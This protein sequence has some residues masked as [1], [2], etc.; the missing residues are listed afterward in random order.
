MIFELGG[1]LLENVFLIFPFPIASVDRTFLLAAF[2]QSQKQQAEFFVKFSSLHQSFV[3]PPPS[4]FLQAWICFMAFQ[5][6]PSCSN[7]YFSVSPN[8]FFLY[9]FF[10]LVP[11]LLLAWLFFFSLPHFLCAL[12]WFLR[13]FRAPSPPF[14][15]SYNH[16]NLSRLLAHYCISVHFFVI[17]LFILNIVTFINLVSMTFA[18]PTWS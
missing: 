17:L 7:N 16:T 18:T 13:F 6:F 8:A 12:Q 5:S 9:F 3:A 4:S 2:Y 14:T 10:L 11:P 1:G 15:V